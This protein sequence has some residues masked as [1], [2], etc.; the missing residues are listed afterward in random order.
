MRDQ[1][2]R[3]VLAGLGAASGVVKRDE[4]AVF[5][6]EGDDA[7]VTARAQQPWKPALAPVCGL[8][9]DRSL[10]ATESGSHG[11]AH[12]P[13]HEI[14]VPQAVIDARPYLQL[15]VTVRRN[16]LC[17]CHPASEMVFIGRGEQFGG[18]VEPE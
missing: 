18:A 7:R 6:C 4:L 11:V 16:R 5:I 15:V 12:H 13:I 8:V 1:R 9:D 3:A 10:P 14:E 17:F 2:R